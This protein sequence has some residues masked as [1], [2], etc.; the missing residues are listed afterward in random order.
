MDHEQARYKLKLKPYRKFLSLAFLCESIFVWTLK[1]L[2]YAS[3]FLKDLYIFWLTIGNIMGRYTMILLIFVLRHVG[4]CGIY[5]SVWLDSSIRMWNRE[6]SLHK[7]KKKQELGWR[8]VVKGNMDMISG[9]GKHLWR[10]TLI[11]Q[12]QVATEHYKDSN[13]K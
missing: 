9:I 5:T 3:I 13:D 8:Q 12:N 11:P 1:F 7:K 10:W 6:I 2:S 4:L